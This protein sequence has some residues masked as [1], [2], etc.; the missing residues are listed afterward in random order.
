ME[1]A[2]RSKIKRRNYK[3]KKG[4]NGKNYRKVGNSKRKEGKTN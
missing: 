3:E 2:E 1:G 4:G